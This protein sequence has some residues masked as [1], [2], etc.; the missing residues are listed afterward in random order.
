MALAFTLPGLTMFAL[1]VRTALAA[2]ISRVALAF[3]LPGLAVLAL[4]VRTA[5]TT[6]FACL[7]LAF[8]LP[9]LTMFALAVRTALAL[10]SISKGEIR[11]RSSAK[12]YQN[13]DNQTCRDNSFQHTNSLP[14]ESL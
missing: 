11:K 2:F 7:A 12:K 14:F 8:A 5:G 6:L 10:Y 3:A 13:A 9:G 4:A 1:A